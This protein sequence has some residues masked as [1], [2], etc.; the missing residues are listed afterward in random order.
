MTM[1]PRPIRWDEWL[2]ESEVYQDLVSLFDDRN[3]AFEE[4]SEAVLTTASIPSI[5]HPRFPEGDRRPQDLWEFNA[6]EFLKGRWFFR[7][8]LG[9]LQLSDAGGERWRILL[10]ADAVYQR[11]PS[12][13]PT[14]QESN[15]EPIGA[16][17]GRKVVY[18]WEVFKTQF[19]LCLY[20]DD[21][22]ADADIN[23]E[24]WAARLI[25]WGSTRLGEKRTPQQSAMRAKISEWVP[26]WKAAKA[27]NK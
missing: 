27:V 11:W 22:S 20:D 6:P 7:P 8:R 12:L 26:I 24:S 18:D 9:E 1:A 3:R 17:R 4:I 14:P 15:A 13:R 16:K 23:I 10:S 2:L 21:V 25:E 19:F 5:R